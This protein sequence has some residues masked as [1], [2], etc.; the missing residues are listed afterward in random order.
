[1]FFLMCVMVALASAP[2]GFAIGISAKG[3]RARPIAPM[4]RTIR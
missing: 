4:R 3:L 2:I 1:M